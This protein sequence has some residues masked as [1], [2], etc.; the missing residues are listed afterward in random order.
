MSCPALPMIKVS[1]G[2]P[3][4]KL[5]VPRLAASAALVALVGAAV[6]CLGATAAGANPGISVSPSTGLHDGQT[7]TVTGSG[8]TKNGT[9]YI[10]ECKSG[11]TSES[12]CSFSFSDLSTV[13]VAKADA[14][15]NLHSPSPALKT[16]F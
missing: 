16:S 2:G 12:Q 10:V 6:I 5:R 11:A 9:V 15:G 7:V 1:E 3:A 4:V 14:S 13:V 8:F